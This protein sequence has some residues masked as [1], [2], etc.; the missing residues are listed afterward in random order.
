VVA[1][2]A[3]FAV[4]T[5]AIFAVGLLGAWVDSKAETWRE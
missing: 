1:A 3:L 2:A 4:L 5:I